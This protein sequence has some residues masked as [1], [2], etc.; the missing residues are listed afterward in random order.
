MRKFV[1][2]A[3]AVAA[4]A[5]AVPASA[6]VFYSNDP[7]AGDGSEGAATPGYGANGGISF[8]YATL[9]RPSQDQ[10]LTRRGHVTSKT[11][12]AKSASHGV[13]TGTGSDY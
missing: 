7:A 1:L 8:G 2:A 11:A 9:G 4:L 10:A 6:Q 5:A 3:V 12:A 13:S